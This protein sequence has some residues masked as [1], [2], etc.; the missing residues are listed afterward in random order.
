M[1]IITKKTLICVLLLL[2]VTLGGCKGSNN[3][4]PTIKETDSKTSGDELP[5]N[6]E[7]DVFSSYSINITSDYIFVYSEPDYESEA[8]CI[9]NEKGTYIVID[10]I[11]NTYSGVL[12]HWVKLKEP[13]GWIILN[14]TDNSDNI[15]TDTPYFYEEAPY[16]ESVDF[17]YEEPV[18][19][20][21]SFEPYEITIQ[22]NELSV[23][24]APGYTVGNELY[25]ITDRRTITIVS[26]EIIYEYGVYRKWGELKTGGWVSLTAAYVVDDETESASA[27]PT[28]TTTSQLAETTT[29][30]A[31]NTPTPTE[32]AP[33]ALDGVLVDD[34]N[35]VYGCGSEHFKEVNG[36]TFHWYDRYEHRNKDNT[37]VF[38]SIDII[39]FEMRYHI[40]E[41]QVDEND[42][43]YI[44]YE[45]NV[46]SGA[47]GK[48]RWLAYDEEDYLVKDLTVMCGDVKGK[49]RGTAWFSQVQMSPDSVSFAELAPSMY[50]ISN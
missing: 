30:P 46:S 50:G 47:S 11:S 19:T 12:L 27:T 14:D 21:A 24:D 3:D 17:P 4:T 9:I 42:I 23:Y 32:T 41:N 16:E 37:I 49:C 45:V 13:D 10:E 44:D 6:D 35:H 34:A 39:S 48:L 15:E 18:E 31:S 8:T 28:D 22:R 33:A 43:W 26:E 25:E 20:D 29:S 36:I 1:K 7:T 2:P 5:D 40:Q 38:S